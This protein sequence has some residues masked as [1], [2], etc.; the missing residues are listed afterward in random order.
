MKKVKGIYISLALIAF[1]YAATATID[2]Y[3]GDYLFGSIDAIC[4]IIVIVSAI[5][6]V[7]HDRKE[8]NL[9]SWIVKNET[10]FQT[11]GMIKLHGKIME[12]LNNDEIAEYIWQ[13][14][15]SVMEDE[16]N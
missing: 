16:K 15:T 11:Q 2:L 10:M 6:W 5:L 14:G 4:A 1:C 12:G 7:R 13:H 9:K 3:Q 8:E